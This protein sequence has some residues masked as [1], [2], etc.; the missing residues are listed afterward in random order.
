MSLLAFDLGGTKLATAVFNEHGKILWRE[1]TPLDKRKGEE[2][3]ELITS[4]ILSLSD[5]ARLSGDEIIS[6]G[7]SVPGIYHSKKGTVWAPNIPEWNDFP[8]LEEIK[9]VAANIPVKIDSDRA[10]YILGE[11]WKGNAQQCDDAIFL[12]VG[13]GIGAGILI[14]GNVLRGAHDIAG[15]I[16]WMALSAPFKKEYVECGCFEHYC[17]GEGIAKVAQQFLCE[18]NDYLGELKNKP[19]KEITCHD[20]FNAYSNNDEIANEVINIC[21][22]FWGMTTA[23]LVSLFNPEKIIFGGGVFGPAI[24]LIPKIKEEATKWAQPISIKQVNLE[25]SG[26]G[27]DA[28][29]FGA[30]FLALNNLHS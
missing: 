18:K 6:V 13:T 21:I 29:V 15:A 23:N 25:A 27:S 16:G 24:P 3:G 17:S 20:I 26:L 7:V 12:A 8:L 11:A 9:K 10:C 30:G 19:I 4:R 2:V 1:I 22:Q 28:G 14:D 5:T